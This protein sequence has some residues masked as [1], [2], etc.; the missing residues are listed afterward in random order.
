LFVDKTSVS[1]AFALTR[2][3]LHK[4][5]VVAFGPTTLRPTIAYNMLAMCDIKPGDVVCDPMMGGGSIPIEAAI[6]WPEAV[7]IGGDIHP[8]AVPR[9]ET[10]VR[11]LNQKRIEAQK[12]PL[13]IDLYSWDATQLPL[14]DAC[15]DVFIT[16]MPFGKR[17]G[18]RMSNWH[19]Y[20]AILTDM[21]RVCKPQGRAC[22]LTHDRKCVTKSIR[23][24]Y[25]LWMWRST[26]TVN[27][28]G[29]AAAV[30]ILYRTACPF[31]EGENYA[32]EASCEKLTHQ[33]VPVADGDTEERS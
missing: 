31:L 27:I 13:L 24:L 8:Q 21:A 23:S 11:H 32:K 18:S 15:V 1:V 22:L 28:G 10:N 30:C 2:E 9:A 17:S 16:D 29:L 5:N 12:S 26:T 33:D 6:N 20:P 4:R 25:K 3:S 14:R 19:L 7:H